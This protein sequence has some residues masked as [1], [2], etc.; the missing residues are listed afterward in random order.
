MH[1]K[2]NDHRESAIL[3]KQKH[4]LC[5]SLIATNGWRSRHHAYR[6][7]PERGEYDE[8]YRSIIVRTDI[9]VNEYFDPFILS[10]DERH[11]RARWRHLS[12]R[13]IFHLPLRSVTNTT[14]HICSSEKFIECRMK[15]ITVYGSQKYPCT[16]ALT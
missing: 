1:N 12:V 7:L 10:S 2:K 9:L 3:K 14:V 8:D 13:V 16:M 15:Y 11:Q 5:N 6:G 4:S